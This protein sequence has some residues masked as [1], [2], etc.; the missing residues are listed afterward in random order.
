MRT[1][2]F[3]KIGLIQLELSNYLIL[4]CDTIIPEYIADILMVQFRAGKSF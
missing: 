3:A 2:S 4:Q 1:W